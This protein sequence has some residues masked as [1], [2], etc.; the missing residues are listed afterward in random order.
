M[1]VTPQTRP[2]AR[3]TRTDK[4]PRSL[5]LPQVQRERS[6]LAERKAT[7]FI[8]N[9]PR[10]LIAYTF[11]QQIQAKTLIITFPIKAKDSIKISREL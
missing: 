11:T 9:G 2:S 8:A 5:F 1:A 4:D 6:S 10:R 3:A 7:R